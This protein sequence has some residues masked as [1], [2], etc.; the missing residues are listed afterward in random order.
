MTPDRTKRYS[1]PVHEGDIILVE[2]MANPGERERRILPAGFS[3]I[4]SG[5]LRGRGEKA[6]I[7]GTLGTRVDLGDRIISPFEPVVVFSNSR[8]KQS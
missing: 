6:R 1:W 5:Q 8:V 4:V 3:G 7:T 2:S